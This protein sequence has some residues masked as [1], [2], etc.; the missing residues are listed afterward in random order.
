MECPCPATVNGNARHVEIALKRN[1]VEERRGIAIL[2]RALA[3]NRKTITLFGA[4]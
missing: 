3:L 4:T 1:I 2:L